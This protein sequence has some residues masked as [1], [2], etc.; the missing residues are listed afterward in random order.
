MHTNLVILFKTLFCFKPAL[1][2]ST[3]AI[4]L[5]KLQLHTFV[6]FKPVFLL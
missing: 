1:H 3:L 2:S 6:S 5:F 4:K